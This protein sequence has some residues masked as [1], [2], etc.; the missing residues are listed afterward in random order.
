MRTISNA[1]CRLC[2][3]EKADLSKVSSNFMM[4]ILIAMAALSRPQPI[5][6]ELNSHVFIRIPDRD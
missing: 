2:G 4:H 5:M 1:D 3:Q 6:M